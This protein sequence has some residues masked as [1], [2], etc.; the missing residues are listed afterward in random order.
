MSTSANLSKI[1]EQ[2]IY[3]ISDNWWRHV[4][5]RCY[6]IP[7]W[8]RFVYK[9][10]YVI[11]KS[12]RIDYNHSNIC[13]HFYGGFIAFQF[14]RP[15]SV[16][17]KVFLL[18]PIKK[19]ACGILGGTASISIIVV[20]VPRLLPEST[21]L[22]TLKFLSLLPQHGRLLVAGDSCRPYVQTNPVLVKSGNVNPD[23]GNGRM[24][25]YNERHL[26]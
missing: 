3:T 23:S 6:A 10:I 17:E 11:L 24:S 8:V 22:S 2:R 4:R 14:F 26:P 7:K 19:F 13:F 12:W 1:W 20:N 5:F 18:R 9:Q 21:P 15:T 16:S 25:T